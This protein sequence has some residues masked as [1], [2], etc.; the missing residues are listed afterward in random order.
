MMILPRIEAATSHWVAVLHTG[1]GDGHISKMLL[2]MEKK[3][4]E[5]EKETKIFEKKRC[6]GLNAKIK[7]YTS[8]KSIMKL[9]LVATPL[10]RY[11]RQ[12]CHLFTTAKTGHNRPLF[13]QDL[14]VAKRLQFLQGIQAQNWHRK[15]Y[16]KNMCYSEKSERFA[17]KLCRGGAGEKA[18][19]GGGGGR[20][21]GNK[22]RRRRRRVLLLPPS[23][24]HTPPRCIPQE[25]S[26]H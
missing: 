25:P 15:R 26:R 24:V 5:K 1:L 8:L 19:R 2:F 9:C 3:K 14:S 10:D 16:W 4:K 20:K 23:Q 13:A 17:T 12:L 21:Q 6:K 22:R 7:Q 18:R 11:F